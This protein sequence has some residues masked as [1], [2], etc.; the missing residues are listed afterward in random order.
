MV[1]EKAARWA[2]G[3]RPARLTE[4]EVEVFRL[5]ARGWT[6]TQIA[7]GSGVSERTGRFHVGNLLEKLGVSNRT[8]VVETSRRTGDGRPGY[9]PSPRHS[10][11]ATWWPARVILT[12]RRNLAYG[13]GH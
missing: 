2:R 6:N 1:T 13:A 9:V 8:E 3:E 10:C 12:A 5:L 7:Q 4:R 11:R